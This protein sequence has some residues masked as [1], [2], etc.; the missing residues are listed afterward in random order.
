MCWLYLQLQ[1]F[2][3]GFLLEIVLFLEFSVYQEILSST[4][5]YIAAVLPNWFK[6]QSAKTDASTVASYIHES[7]LKLKMSWEVVLVRCP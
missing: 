6:I 2:H 1:T 5:H 3:E 4:A 7:S